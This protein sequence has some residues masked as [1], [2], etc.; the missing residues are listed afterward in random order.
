MKL[1]EQ[2]LWGTP[3]AFVHPMV[4]VVARLFLANPAHQDKIK[5]VWGIC[6]GR[7]AIRKLEFISGLDSSIQILYSILPHNETEW[8]AHHTTLAR[9]FAFGLS[10][11]YAFLSSQITPSVLDISFDPLIGNAGLLVTTGCGQRVWISGECVL[12]RL[13]LALY[14][15]RRVPLGLIFDFEPHSRE[16]G[17]FG[18]RLFRV[19]RFRVLSDKRLYLCTVTLGFN[20]DGVLEGC[21]NDKP[22]IILTTLSILRCLKRLTDKLVAPTLLDRCSKLLAL[23]DPSVKCGALLP[24]EILPSILLYKHP[25]Q[26]PPLARCL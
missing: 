14:G 16:D 17:V 8:I 22:N 7:P 11:R 3:L 19:R 4:P 20:A 18:L 10:N 13:G 24:T 26:T 9:L 6:A 5:A 23:A 15:S 1:N 21:V 12:K 2:N 25:I